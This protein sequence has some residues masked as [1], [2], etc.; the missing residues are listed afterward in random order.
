MKPSKTKTCNIAIRKIQ[1]NDIND[2]IIR[3]SDF[4]NFDFK[5]R[6]IRIAYDSKKQVMNIFQIFV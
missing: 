2:I 1:Y 4:A 3:F 5:I 6:L